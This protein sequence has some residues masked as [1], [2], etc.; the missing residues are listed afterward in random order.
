[1]LP[2]L[3]H[4]PAQV[5]HQAFL[6]AVGQKACKSQH[7][8]PPGEFGYNGE[9]KKPNNTFVAEIETCCGVCTLPPI[10]SAQRKL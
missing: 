8:A 5:P 7:L 2:P 3:L 6:P 1:M 10:S 4:Q 9:R